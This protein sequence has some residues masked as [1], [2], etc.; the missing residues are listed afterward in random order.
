MRTKLL[1]KGKTI[2]GFTSVAR[3]LGISEDELFGTRL[4]APVASVPIRYGSVCSGVEAATVAWAPLGWQAQWFAEIEPF[5]CAVLAHHYPN[6]PNLGDMTRIYDK[7]AFIERDIDLLVGGTPCQSWSSAGKGAGLA[8]P[9]GQLAIEFLR[10]AAIKKPQW[11][12]WENVPRVLSCH[13]GMDFAAFLGEIRKLGY[14]CT[15]RVLDA[16]YFG[17]PQRR[18]RVFLVG[19]L[20][21]WRPA[22][23]ALF[24]PKDLL[25]T[26]QSKK[27]QK[28]R[29][30]DY[31]KVLSDSDLPIGVDTFNDAVTGDVA[32]TLG[33]HAYGRTNIGPKILDRHGIRTP[34]PIECE[35]LMGVPDN[36]TLVDYRCTARQL[37]CHRIGALGNSMVVP[38]MRWIGERIG[39][40]EEVLPTWKS[41]PEGTIQ[42]SASA[43]QNGEGRNCVA[44]GATTMDSARDRA[45]VSG[46][47]TR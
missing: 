35:R 2:S 43:L 10:I 29:L 45:M 30:S 36:Y 31:L 33:A 13:G 39:M 1:C 8:D 38:V 18:R 23:L 25:P 41:L 16:Q 27:R 7:P 6:V 26:P 9:R 14:G 22:A 44:K 32:A 28:M 17:V 37:E 40:V 12:V 21:D 3:D 24:E 11:L 46:G 19:H 4:K 42:P 5:P 20:G 34:T 15:Y 47:P